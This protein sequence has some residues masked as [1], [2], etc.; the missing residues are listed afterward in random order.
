MGLQPPVAVGSRTMMMDAN[1]AGQ[2]PSSKVRSKG[3]CVYKDASVCVGQTD[4]HATMQDG[5]ATGTQESERGR[6]L[7]S[8]CAVA[9]PQ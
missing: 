7:G 4:T 2:Q 1:T 5:V 6:C 8:R 3:V 9:L